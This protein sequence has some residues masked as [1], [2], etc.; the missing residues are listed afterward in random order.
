MSTSSHNREVL[1][2]SPCT[3]TLNWTPPNPTATHSPP[4][5]L[6]TSTH[7]RT[8]SNSSKHGSLERSPSLQE[9]F[10]TQS[11]Q[12]ISCP[13][14][15]CNFFF[16]SCGIG[17]KK[18]MLL[19]NGDEPTEAAISHFQQFRFRCRKCLE[20]FCSQ[21]KKMPY[22]EGYTCSEYVSEESS[23]HCRFCDKLL[24]DKDPVVIQEQLNKLE[25]N[26]NTI[27]DNVCDSCIPKL[28]HTHSGTMSC[29]HQK[30]CTAHHLGSCY[31]C[32]H[33]D[34]VEYVWDCR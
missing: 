7:N 16:E 5:S 34:C 22:H 21:C 30:H 19:Q 28:S 23:V 31:P 29:R 4:S 18:Q 25:K 26:V 32:I 2:P 6:D 3:D 15:R 8:P 10:R 12:L 13:N 1:S 11:T 20:D 27:V 9:F 33:P 24:L 17:V 14:P